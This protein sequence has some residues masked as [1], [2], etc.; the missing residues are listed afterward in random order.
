MDTQYLDLFISESVQH[1]QAMSAGLLKLER[2]PANLKTIQDIFRSAHTIKGMAAT[3]GFENMARL[4]HELENGLGLLREGRLAVTPAVMDALFACMRVLDQHLDWVTERAEDAGAIGRA[5]IERLQQTLA[6]PSL[7]VE[8]QAGEA[9]GTESL[10]RLS[11]RRDG[12]G[13]VPWYVAVS[14]VRTAIKM[15]VPAWHVRFEFSEDCPMPAARA[16][17]ALRAAQACGE[18]LG[19]QPDVTVVESGQCNGPLEFVWTGDAGL[20]SLEGAIS[21]VADVAIHTVSL[22]D[23]SALAAA[24]ALLDTESAVVAARDESPAAGVDRNRERILTRTLRVDVDRLDQLMNLASELIIDKTRLELL[25]STRVD[26]ELQETVRHLGRVVADLQDIVLKVRM[27]PVE[28]VFNRFPRMVRDL[29]T[30]LGKR[31]ELTITGAETELDRTLIEEIADPLVHLIRNAIDHGLETPE[32]RR[33]AGKPEVGQLTLRAHPIGERVHIEIE[34]DGRGIDRESVLE[35]A[36]SKGWMTAGGAG[37]ADEQV[38]DMLFQPGFSTVDTVSDISGRGVGLDVVKTKIEAINGSVRVNSVV[39]DGSRFIIDLPL[40]LSIVRALLVEV[41]WETY[42]IPISNVVQLA[43]YEPSE[44]RTMDGRN[45][46]WF[47][48]QWIPLIDLRIVLCVPSSDGEGEHAS[49]P[50]SVVIVGKG[51]RFAA[52]CVSRLV[53]QQEVVQKSAGACFHG[54]PVGVSGATILG[55][56]RVAVILDPAVWVK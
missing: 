5:E 54:L 24:A 20:A 32:V 16:Y 30:S 9:L 11:Y 45:M 17:L 25:A 51:D 42:V 56:G 31:V 33:R 53:G 40:T 36:R 35:K 18:V 4:T 50:E 28:A 46:I 23:V 39:G 7:A 6:A 34:D 48:G 1:L 19:S 29:S 41:G 27:V 15:G 21:G 13:T 38:Y 55:D 12:V 26:A 8:R 43:R 2:T 44:I 47:D 52:L 22:L 37:L 14:P 49:N 10:P 3:M